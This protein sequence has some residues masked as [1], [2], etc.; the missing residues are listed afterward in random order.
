MITDC[1]DLSRLD[2]APLPTTDAQPVR[3]L[4]IIPALGQ[5][6]AERLLA[7][8]L[9]RGAGRVRHSVL[10][11]LD[12]PPF[13]DLGNTA[14]A[15]LGLRRGQV[16]PAA[17]L[18]AASALRAAAPDLIHAWLYHGNLLSALLPRRRGIPV[19][20]SIHN[21]TLPADGAKAMTRLVN[22]LCAHLSHRV[23]WRIV[24]CAEA[25]RTQHEETF[26]YDRARGVVV[27]NGVDFAAFAFDPARRVALRAAWGLEPGALAIGCVGRFDPQKDHATVLGAV[28]RLEGERAR[29]VLAGAGCSMDNPALVA[30]LR[31]A[32]L[33][34]RTL[35]LGPVADMPG[36][37]SALD[38]L[39]IGSAFGEALPMVGLEAAASGLPVVATAVGSVAELVLDPAHLVPPR[40]P[41]A[42]AAAILA[43]LPL[44]DLQRPSPAAEARRENLLRTHDIATTVARYHDLYRAGAAA[45]PG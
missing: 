39:V 2:P 15:S 26:G 11:L 24:Y 8:L 25:A 7:E 28:S 42:L 21:T 12:Q 36:L 44:A 38:L 41:A 19:L 30:L 33:M 6:G 40:D 37:L 22:R 13:F 35:V 10:T 16:S 45:R 27:E 4:H 9:A 18:R 34:D 31:D 20:W 3:V 17:L 23:P 29:L 32:G 43:A 1:A 5:G 14:I